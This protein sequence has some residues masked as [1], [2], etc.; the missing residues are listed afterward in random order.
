MFLDYLAKLWDKCVLCTDYGGT[1]GSRELWMEAALLATLV[2]L[3]RCG[4]TR[5]VVTE[6]GSAW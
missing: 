4:D 5:S 3:T 6:E 2:L 1:H